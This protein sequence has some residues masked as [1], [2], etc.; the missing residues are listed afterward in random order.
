MRHLILNTK[1]KLL[2][3]LIARQ[4]LEHWAKILVAII[5]VGGFFS[6]AYLLFLRVFA[7]LSTV[8]DIGPVLVDRLISIG[9]LAFF[10]M[11][12]ISNLVSSISTLFRSTESEYLMAT[13]LSHAQ[14]FWSRFMDNFIYS[15]WA[16]AIIGLPMVLAYVIVNKLPFWQVLIAALLLFLSLIHI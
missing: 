11:L 12:L 9:F 15:S 1:R 13:P 14:V 7:Y 16:T 4:G 8:Q 6:A 3:R 10:S 2:W 5:I